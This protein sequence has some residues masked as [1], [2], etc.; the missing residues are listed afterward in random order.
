LLWG[1]KLYYAPTFSSIDDA[2]NEASKKL[3]EQGLVKNDDV[4]VFVGS[5]PIQAK[6]RTNMVK[7]TKIMFSILLFFIGPDR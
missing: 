6:G 1:A 7:L 3:A 2:V 5:T 4:L